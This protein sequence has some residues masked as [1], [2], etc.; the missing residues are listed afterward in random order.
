LPRSLLPRARTTSDRSTSDPSTG[1][2]RSTGSPRST[3]SLLVT[4]STSVLRRARASHGTALRAG[5]GAVLLLGVTAAVQGMT[6]T[7][8]PVAARAA[9]FT[10]VPSVV[11]TTDPLGNPDLRQRSLSA[12]TR[13]QVLA[14]EA[15]ARAAQEAA[16]SAARR[17]EQAQAAKRTAAAKAAATR[18][19]ATRAAAARAAAARAAAAKAAAARA[20]KAPSS[21]ANTPVSSG[22]PRSI[23]RQLLAARAWSGQFGCLNALWQRES[24]WNSRAMN[25][26]SGAY[27]IPQALPG[28]KMASAGG[29]WRTNPATQIRWGL[30]YIAS[31]YGTP[32]GAWAH[33]QSHGWY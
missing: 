7:N 12:A 25:P 8:T 23:A 5:A 32:C 22:D 20:A 17:A 19:A 26:S 1:S 16:R 10:A 6:E 33:S 31:T 30:S 9:E 4:G 28:S 21:A 15:R 27:G 2:L 14:Q 3:G 13:A 29:D 18:A 11:P 24:G